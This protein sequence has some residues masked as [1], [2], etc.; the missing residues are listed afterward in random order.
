M[1]ENTNLSRFFGGFDCGCFGGWLLPIIVIFLIFMVGDD[2]L[3]FI[4]CEDSA[5]IWIILIVMLLFFLQED[6]CC[7]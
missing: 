3:E 5:I 4:F 1:S 2:L 7:C 6:D